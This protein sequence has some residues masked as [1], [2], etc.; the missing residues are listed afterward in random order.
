MNSTDILAHEFA[1]SILTL[2]NN[3]AIRQQNSG[4]GILDI[5]EHVYL[6]LARE[7]Y[8]SQHANEPVLVN[9]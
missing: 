4:M 5:P 9:K 3:Q 8:A 1:H 2:F 7:Y 6:Y